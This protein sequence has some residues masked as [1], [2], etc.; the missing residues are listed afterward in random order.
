MRNSDDAKLIAKAIKDGAALIAGAT[1]KHGRQTTPTMPGYQIPER[2]SDQIL[3][4][5]SFADQSPDME[6]T[7]TGDDLTGDDIAE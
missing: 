2:V 6:P 5:N 1:E 7:G 4:R 3:F